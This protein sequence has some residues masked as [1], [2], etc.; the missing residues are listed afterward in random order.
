MINPVCLSFAGPCKGL[1][2]A[3]TLIFQEQG[4]QTL[5]ILGVLQNL[6][7]KG[8]SALELWIRMAL[9]ATASCMCGCHRV[10]LQCRCTC[11]FTCMLC[12]TGP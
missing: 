3:E 1:A 10:P 11:T 9:V 2:R 5:G 12:L 4:A 7:R 6:L 8:A